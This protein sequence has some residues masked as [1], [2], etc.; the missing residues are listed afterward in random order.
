MM[1]AVAA[2]HRLIDRLPQVRGRL[3]EQADLSKVTW[4]QVGG[5]AE[6]LFKPE[7][8]DDLSDFLANRPKDVTVFPIGVG[9]NILVRDGGIDNV[10]LR[11]GRKFTKMSVEKD[12][13]TVGAGSLDLNAAKFA[14]EHSLTGAEF[15]SGIPGTIGGALRMNAGAYGNELKDILISA[16][17]YDD[18]GVRHQLSNA[19]IGFSYRHCSIPAD[20]VFTEATF[21]LRAGNRDEILS[22]MADIQNSR[23]DSQPIKSKT[24]GSTFANPEGHKAWQLIDDVGARGLT[25]GDAMVSEKHCNFLINKGNASA[26]DIEAVGIEARRR[27]FAEH[28]ILLRWELV[29]VGNASPNEKGDVE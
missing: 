26:A 5:P 12:V 21:R 2:K 9:S 19:D 10:V 27:V 28:D 20:W 11:L 1:A 25:I 23:Q 16:V 8:E 17:A 29:R 13:L 6:I 4:F 15:L 7:D 22:R 3:R 18:D 24:G 14:A